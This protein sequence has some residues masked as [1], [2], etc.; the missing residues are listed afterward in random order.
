MT[1][2]TWGPSSRRSWRTIFWRVPED[3][4]GVSSVSE[5]GV[6]EPS[7]VSGVLPPGVC[8]SALSC[9][10]WIT[11]LEDAGISLLAQRVHANVVPT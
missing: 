10:S 5:D 1:A 2:R 8:S 6:G 3:W 7:R 11:V 4:R 9:T